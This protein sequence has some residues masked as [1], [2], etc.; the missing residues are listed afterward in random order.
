MVENGDGRIRGADDDDPFAPPV[1]REVEPRAGYRYDPVE[2][3][4]E[5]LRPPP[6]APTLKHSLRDTDSSETAFRFK[7]FTYS[8]AGGIIIALGCGFGAR[9]LGM[10]AA[11][12]A[13]GGGFVFG[14]YFTY[15]G[16]LKLTTSAGHAGASVY[17]PSGATTPGDRQYSLAQSYAARGLY[18]RAAAEY[19]KNTNEYPDD[20]EPFMRLARLY[21]DELQRYD[22]AILWFKR[23]CAIPNVP[24]ATEIMATRELIEV[25]THRM[26]QPIPAAPHLARLAA[27]HPNTP[28]GDWAKRTL[29]DMKAAMRDEQSSTPNEMQ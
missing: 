7:I 27:R 14:W 5:H 26:H 13:V 25:Y 19:E 12:L 10:T 6:P 21:R 29:A 24:A 28:A 17:F 4:P 11:L 16:V 20:P 8:G 23:T 1:P 15:L 2:P 22:D 18:P 9:G 3:I